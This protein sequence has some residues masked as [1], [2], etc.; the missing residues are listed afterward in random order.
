[1]SERKARSRAAPWGTREETQTSSGDTGGEESEENP[2]RGSLGTNAVWNMDTTNERGVLTLIALFCGRERD[3]IRLCFTGVHHNIGD[4][5]R[6]QA[7]DVR[8]TVRGL[9][10]EDDAMSRFD[11]G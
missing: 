6:A 8:P 11:S 7:S 3:E 9:R 10:V 5:Q 1:M 4:L 2:L